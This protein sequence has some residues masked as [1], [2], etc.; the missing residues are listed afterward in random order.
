MRTLFSA[1]CT[2]CHPRKPEDWGDRPQQASLGRP[3]A[4]PGPS[5]T[6]EPAAGRHGNAS[7][8][9][10]GCGGGCSGGAST[11]AGRVSGASPSGLRGSGSLS[12]EACAAWSSPSAR[13]TRGLTTHIVDSRAHIRSHAP[14]SS[15]P[16]SAGPSGPSGQQG[17]RVISGM[18]K[19]ERA[20]SGERRS[21]RGRRAQQEKRRS[22]QAACGE[23]CGPR[24]EKTSSNVAAGSC[25]TC[26]LRPT[27]GRKRLG[28]RNQR[29]GVQVDW[30]GLHHLFDGA[31][32]VITVA[33]TAASSNQRPAPVAAPTRPPR[34]RAATA[35]HQNPAPT[36]QPPHHNQSRVA[37]HLSQQI[38]RQEPQRTGRSQ[39]DSAP[40][41]PEQKPLCGTS[42]TTLL[43]RTS[44]NVWTG[45]S[46]GSSG[47]N[48]RA[49]VHIEMTH[50]IVHDN[51]PSVH[52]KM[53]SV[54]DDNAM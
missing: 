1:A 2:Q 17:Q 14:A 40:A 11:A 27:C 16:P 43:G 24:S 10:G 30:T 4:T 38:V 18:V 45:G 3:H 20:V 47:D 41:A 29:D 31:L 22:K 9:G 6:P 32:E 8:G 35:A 39:P 13:P 42:G 7:C 26:S 19:R 52:D 21:R 54:N 46:A 25:E 34:T 5:S 15:P 44:V 48:E 33:A 50:D 23:A 51:M 12:G 28:Q 49:R 53:P 37:A 36:P